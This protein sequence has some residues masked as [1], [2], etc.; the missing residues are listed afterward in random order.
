M[1][2]N[3]TDPAGANKVDVSPFALPPLPP[4]FGSAAVSAFVL[5]PLT[6]DFTFNARLVGFFA[7][8]ASAGN[9]QELQLT[10]MLSGGGTE[11]VSV[12]GPGTD[13]QPFGFISTV[14][15]TGIRFNNSVNDG[16]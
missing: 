3:G 10:S 12:P 4:S 14:P 5:G 1:L 8:F 9:V 6:V 11:N 13:L 2:T 7:D 16:F 15:I